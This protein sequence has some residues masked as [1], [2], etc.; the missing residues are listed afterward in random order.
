[1]DLSGFED[2]NGDMDFK[3]TGTENGI[4]SIQLDVKIEG[5]T[6][7]MVAETVRLAEE[8][9]LYVIDQMKDVIP[10]PRETISEYAPMLEMM[11]IDV[12]QIGG[13]IGPAGRNIK[14]IIAETGADIDIDEDGR[15]FIS[16]TEHEGV[17]QAK[18]IIKAMTSEIEEGSEFVGKVVRIMPFAAFIEL[19]PGRDGFLHISNIAERRIDKV[20]DVLNMGDEVPVR[21]EEVDSEGKISLIRTDIDY[22]NRP[23]RP[24]KGDRDR[25]GGGRDRGGRDRGGRDRGGRD[26]GGRDRRDRGRRD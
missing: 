9:Y 1:M 5:L 21:V 13:V 7:D 25:R 8:G 2:F 17:N 26:R 23:P 24:P 18:A 22:G 6:V 14:K 15:V 19:V 20:E 4:T 3:V 10:G 16:G 12:D 11:Q